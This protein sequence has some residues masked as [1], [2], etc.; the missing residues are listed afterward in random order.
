MRI[1]ILLLLGL[2]F[3]CNRD[4]ESAQQAEAVAQS[5]PVIAKGS[6]VDLDAHAD[7]GRI[8]IFDFYADWC[9]PCKELDKSLVDM[10][11]VYGD[12][13][14]VYKLDLVNW[15]SDLAK[16]HGIRDLPYLIVYDADRKLIKQGPS[17]QV[18]PDLVA[19]L[20]R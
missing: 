6:V 20:N 13:I 3:A 10:K 2:L 5:F 7:Q 14:S 16:H 12:R 15:G 4:G 19:L 8:T 1:W 11:M 9:P 18:L 17:N